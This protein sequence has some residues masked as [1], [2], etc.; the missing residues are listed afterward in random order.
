MK[1]PASPSIPRGTTR[2]GQPGRIIRPP[3][4]A[5]NRRAPG[6]RPESVRLDTTL[7]NAFTERQKSPNPPK[8][9]AKRGAHRMVPQTDKELERW[10]DFRLHLV[11]TERAAC[12]E[13]RQ[14][15]HESFRVTQG[16]KDDIVEVFFKIDIDTY[17]PQTKLFGLQNLTLSDV[18]STSEH[19]LPIHVSSG[20]FYL[21]LDCNFRRLFVLFSDPYS[22]L[23]GPEV[24]KRVQNQVR[25]NVTDY[26]SVQP[27]GVPTSKRHSK[28]E[29]WLLENPELCVRPESRCGVFHGAC[30][31]KEATNHGG[32]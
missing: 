13:A 29:Q 21:A 15:G 14:N 23:Y 11:K 16:C 27:P 20:G 19:Y 24:G 9:A 1:E 28:Y 10:L 6:Q 18:E 4:A 22:L 30:G 7:F 2:S 3:Y 26:A 17:T 32:Q 12:E 31:W 5:N 8:K 25:E